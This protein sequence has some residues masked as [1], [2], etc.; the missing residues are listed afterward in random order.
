LSPWPTSWHGLSGL[1]WH[2]ANPTRPRQ[3]KNWLTNKQYLGLQ[4]SS[5]IRWNSSDETITVYP[6]QSLSW[7][8]GHQDL[9][10]A[11]AVGVLKSH[12]GSVHRMYHCEA[13]YLSKTV[14]V[15][16][17]AIGDMYMRQKND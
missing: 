1:C 11:E 8:S 7:D 9:V 13:G 17:E 15:R 14:F 10:G 2:Q 4:E 16:L 12:Q 5:P 3:S 6:C